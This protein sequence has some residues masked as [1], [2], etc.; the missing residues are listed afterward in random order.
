MCARVNPDA[1]PSFE[2]VLKRSS[3]KA[4]ILG[5]IGFVE[6]QARLGRRH[7]MA[8]LL[9]TEPISHRQFVDSIHAASLV[10]PLAGEANKDATGGL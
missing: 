10:R 4:Q 7:P 9:P 2:A 1:L 3:N 5:E 6:I 8:P